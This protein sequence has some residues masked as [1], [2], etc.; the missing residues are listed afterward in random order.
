[1]NEWMNECQSDSECYIT[2]DGQSVSQSWNNAPVWGL[3]PYYYY[4][5][6]VAGLL[7]CGALTGERRGLS[8][9]IAP[10]PCQRNHFPVRVPWDSWPYVTSWDLR[11]PFSSPPT[12]LSRSVILRPTV[13]RS[14]CL[15]KRHPSGAYDHIFVI[16]RQLR[17][18]SC[19]TLSLARGRVCRLQLLLVIASAVIFASE[20]H[21]THD[22]ILLSQIRDFPF[23]RLLRLAGL[24][25]RYSTLPPK[26]SPG[27]GSGSGSGSYFTTDGQSAS[28]FWNKF[29]FWGLRPDLYY[30]QTLAGLLMWSALSDERTGL[31]FTAAAGPRQRSHFCVQVPWDSWPCFTVSDSRLPFSS[32][33][34]VTVE[35]FD[36]TS[37][38]ENGS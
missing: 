4:C 26:G 20:S 11:L 10:G 21:G 3:R 16:V 12:T 35:V 31:Q 32:P 8:F 1:M 22:H 36:P 13:S 34:R 25:W 28:L 37:I 30:C 29:P 2:T 18:C 27:S 14:V 19:G 38:R 24:R 5:Q 23:R 7:V 9:T 15:G 6:T 33:R 17:V